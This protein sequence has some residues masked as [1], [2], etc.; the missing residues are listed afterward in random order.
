MGPIFVCDDNKNLKIMDWGFNGWGKKTPFEKDALLRER[1]SKELGIER[2]DL[3]T[4][5]LEGGA[6]ELDGNG[7]CLS[8]RSAVTNK[9]RN[10]KLSEA[11]IEKYIK[12]KSWCY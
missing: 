4:V 10:P 7:T 6:I 11:E 3:K 2:I 9:N 8:T 12:R 5:I 1:L